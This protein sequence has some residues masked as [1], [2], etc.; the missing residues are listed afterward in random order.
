LNDLVSAIAERR[1]DPY[2]VVEQIIRNL[3]FQRLN[4]S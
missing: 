2:S 4:I 1:Q 3:R